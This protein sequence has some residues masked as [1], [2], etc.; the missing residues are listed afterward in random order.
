MIFQINT[1]KMFGVRFS[2]FVEN[3]VE[4]WGQLMLVYYRK[5]SKIP[6]GL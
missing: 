1:V 5:A 3:M 4:N 6:L 2:M